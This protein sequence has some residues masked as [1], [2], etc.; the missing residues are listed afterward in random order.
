M[1][2]GG[3]G[4]ALSRAAPVSAVVRGS[5]AAGV[6]RGTG[7]RGMVSITVAR[8]AA[9]SESTVSALTRGAESWP[10][11][12]ADCE[13]ASAAPAP[14]APSAHAAAMDAASTARSARR[15]VGN[16]AGGWSGTGGR[17]GEGD[18]RCD[19]QGTMAGGAGR[20]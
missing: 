10:A 16:G 17:S 8:R 6:G 13:D 12:G 14:W 19:A 7:G 4:R 1:S 5:A 2:A 9:V 18:E 20:A 3:R 11:P 15:R